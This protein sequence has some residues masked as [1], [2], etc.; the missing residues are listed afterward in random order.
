MVHTFE[1]TKGLYNATELNRSD[2]SVQDCIH[3]ALISAQ[4]I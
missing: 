4:F 1:V 2:A 3:S